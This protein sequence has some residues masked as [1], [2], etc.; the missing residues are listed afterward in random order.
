MVAEEFVKIKEID[1]SETI[2]LIYVQQGPDIVEV[3]TDHEC[4]RWNEDQIRQL[5][6]RYHYELINGG[7]AVGSFDNELLVGFGVLAHNFRGAK[8]DQ[9]QVDLMYV[10]QNYRRQGIAT[11]I[12][13]EVS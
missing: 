12:I 5:E 6:E 4:G 1:R 7:T 2:N 3:V 11:R 8:S 9:L 10:S 13:Q